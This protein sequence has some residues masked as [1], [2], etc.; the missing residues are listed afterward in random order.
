MYIFFGV[1][2]LILGILAYIGATQRVLMKTVPVQARCL[3]CVRSPG[4]KG[5]DQYH[6]I[7]EVEM[8]GQK[9]TS[10]SLSYVL[11]Y[12][13]SEYAE[14]TWHEI[15][16]DT[17]DPRTAFHRKLT[18]WDH[19]GSYILCTLFTAIGVILIFFAPQVAAFFA[20]F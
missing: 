10:R 3:G 8:N 17:A 2:I 15:W 4:F 20:S 6:P 12:Q 1:I 13:T 14:G 16:V 7:F 19:I 9:Y 11:K 18:I 5:P